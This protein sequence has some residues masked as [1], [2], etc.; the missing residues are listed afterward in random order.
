VVS[1]ASTA[2]VATTSAAVAAFVSA[3]VNN[4]LAFAKYQ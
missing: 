3:D 1:F 2:F 4:S